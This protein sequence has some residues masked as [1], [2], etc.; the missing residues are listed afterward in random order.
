MG[1]VFSRSKSIVEVENSVE[2]P[3]RS[4]RKPGVGLVP[5]EEDGL[6]QTVEIRR[7]IGASLNVLFDL[8]VRRSAELIVKPL[9][10]VFCHITACGRM[11]VKTMH[12][13]G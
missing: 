10:D 9:L 2:L 13:V 3:A 11:S 4:A 7:A 12:G 1:R 8:P 6:L 5:V